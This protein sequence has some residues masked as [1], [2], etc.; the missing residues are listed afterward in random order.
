M[1]NIIHRDATPAR[2]RSF[3]GAAL[4]AIFPLLAGAAQNDFFPTD[5]VALPDGGST[6]A[7]YAA[8]QM[9]NGPWHNGVRLPFG[10]DAR[11]NLLA[12]RASR[13]FSIGDQG[14]YAIAPVVVLSAADSETNA[15]LSG[16]VGKRASGIG[17]L[18]LGT[19]FWFHIDRAN[20]EYALASIMVVLPTGDY[21]PSQTLN[22]GENRV[23]T[24]LSLGWMKTIRERWVME[25]VPEIA[26][27]GDNTKFQSTHRLSQDT[28]YAVTGNLR[29]KFTPEVQG[30]VSAQLNRG[31]ATQ[32]DGVSYSSAPENTRLAVGGLWF[33]GEQ[34]QIQLR[35]AQDVQARNGYRNEGEL[36]LR[37][38]VFFK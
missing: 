8:Q 3:S 12:I 24:I 5:L 34:S 13:G 32:F 27:F 15:P 22:I 28:A 21:S 2:T 30:Y 26:F 11:T 1:K 20:R 37:W 16:A 29:Y 4:L 10:G 6:I 17:D 18:R 35:Y 33:T 9:L 7:V 31:G 23:K 14:Q 38:S 19:A 25:L 36:A